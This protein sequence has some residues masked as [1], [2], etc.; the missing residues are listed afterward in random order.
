MSGAY[1]E[2][3][4]I[5]VRQVCFIYAALLPVNK[6]VFMP[7]VLAESGGEDFLISLAVNFLIDGLILAAVL[8]AAEKK[9]GLTL[10][11]TLERGYN[12]PTA[13]VAYM[14]LAAFFL[15]KSVVPVFELKS[16]IESTLYEMMPHGAIFFIFFIV[17]TYLS[18]K[19]LK[20]IGRCADVAVWFSLAGV[21]VCLFLS[22]GSADYSNLLPIFKKPVYNTVI[23]SLSTLLWHGDA[24]YIFLMIG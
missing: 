5:K 13:K 15:I 20:I 10:Y 9:R 16:Y 21:A 4:L 7:S 3:N 22:V 23:T 8:F 14:I 12:P 19:G 11:R 2:K 17:S 1:N 24:M 6:F 18:L